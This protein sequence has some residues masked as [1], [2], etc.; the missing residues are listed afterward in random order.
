MKITHIQDNLGSATCFLLDGKYLW[1]G[2]SLGGAGKIRKVSASDPTM[3]FFDL[4]VPNSTNVLKLAK[5]TYPYPDYAHI[6]MLIDSPTYIGASCLVGNP[7][8]SF[9]F[10]SPPLGVTERPVDILTSKENYSY[11]YIL[12][13][14]H[15]TNIAKIAYYISTL[16]SPTDTVDLS[17]DG[18]DIHEASGMVIDNNRIIWVVTYTNP[19]QL[20]QC[21][22]T[23][24]GPNYNKPTIYAI[25]P[26]G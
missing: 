24:P 10:F 2:Y 26:L 20:V 1:I 7:I 18:T 6:V 19:A 15:D 12:F 16:G 8:N 11:T 9:Q 22:L 3:I 17:K 4:T 5:T 13:P 14:G 23:P 21:P 25:I